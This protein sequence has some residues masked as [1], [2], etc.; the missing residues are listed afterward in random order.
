M[1]SLSLSMV[2]GHQ[3]HRLAILH[4]AKLVGKAFKATSPN[5]RFSEGAKAISKRTLSRIEVIGKNLFYFFDTDTVL[6]FHFGMSGRFSVWNEAEAEAPKETTRLELRGHGLVGHL[7]AM[8]VQHGDLELYE[9]KKQAL[10]ED[11][12]RDDAVATRAW[13]KVRA[14]KKS[15]GALVMD[16]SVVAGVGNIYRAELLYKAGLHPDTPGNMLTEA[17]WDAVWHHA[18]DLLMRGVVSGSIITVDPEENLPAPWTRRYIYNQS[19]CGRCRGRIVSWSIQNRTA[20]ACPTC[21]PRKWDSSSLSAPTMKPAVV[22]PSHC[23]RDDLATLLKTPEKLTMKQL[24]TVLESRGQEIKSSAKKAELVA[25]VKAT[26]VKTPD[27]K[28]ETSR[29]SREAQT[30]KRSLDLS[31]LDIVAPADAALE[32]RRAGEGKHVEHVPN[33]INL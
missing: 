17:Q 4:R 32:K 19:S 29:G 5:G 11:P 21:Q 15:I 12:V 14:S 16:Q 24:K 28:V 1:L 26:D 3:C 25:L 8:T 7:S 2:E 10:G 23:A 9:K 31:L 22:F 27:I 20:Y 30:A 33:D 18:K 6:H 13:E